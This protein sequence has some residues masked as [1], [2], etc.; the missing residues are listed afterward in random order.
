MDNRHEK[1]I[2]YIDLGQEFGV[3]LDGASSSDDHSSTDL[4]TLDASEKSAH[5]ITRLSSVELLVE[6]L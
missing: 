3:G 6:H 4:F 5:V 1:Q 2:A